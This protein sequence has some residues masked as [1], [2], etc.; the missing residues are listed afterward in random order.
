NDPE[1]CRAALARKGAAESFDALMAA[2]ARWLA[3]VPRVDDLRGRQKVSGKPTPEQAAEL[4]RVKEE[5]RQLEQEL[6]G[7]E[8][9]RDAA[10]A[11]VPNPPHPTA[12]DGASEEDAVELRRVG[13][14][15][16]LASVRVHLELGRFDMERAARLSGSR[17]GYVIGSTAL[18]E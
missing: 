15:P 11:L 17:F 4:K 16:R 3:L 18:L 10:L 12:P 7:A 13:T 9:A 8:A 14:P 2:D 1:G 5:L 6:A